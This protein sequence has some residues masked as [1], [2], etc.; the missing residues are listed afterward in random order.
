M[1]QKDFRNCPKTSD[2]EVPEYFY[3]ELSVQNLT[4]NA[5]SFFVL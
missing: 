1:C 4:Y 3:V 2:V 5:L